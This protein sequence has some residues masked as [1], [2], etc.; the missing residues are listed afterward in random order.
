MSPDSGINELAGLTPEEQEKQKQE[1]SAELAK[2]QNS[3]FINNYTNLQLSCFDYLSFILT[4]YEHPDTSSLLV[5][6][7]YSFIHY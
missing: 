4:V 6:L 5:C 2:V 3:L 1:W 7:I